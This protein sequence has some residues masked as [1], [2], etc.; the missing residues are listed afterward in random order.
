MDCSN[1]NKYI[2]IGII[3]NGFVGKATQLLKSKYT[4]V[5][6]YDIDPSKCIPQN[7]TIDIINTCDVIFIAVPT[8]MKPDGSCDTSIIESILHKLDNP[9]IIIRS[10][11]PVGFSHKHSCHFMPEFL[12]EAN[13]KNDFI[14]NKKWI[15]GMNQTDKNSY[16]IEQLKQTI[17]QLINNAYEDENCEIKYNDVIF[18]TNT[19]AELIK[20]IANTYLSTKVIYFNEI[21]ELCQSLHINYQSII[22]T[23]SYDERIGST[24]MKVPGYNNLK[25]Y[26]GT[27][28]PKDTNNL[29]SIMNEHNIYP[30]ILESNLFKNEFCY[31]KEH[32]WLSDYGRTLTK[33]NKKVILIT[34]GAGFIGSHL[35]RSQLN[36]GNIVICID[37]LST[38][39]LQNIKDI[40]SHPDFYFKKHDIIHKLYIPHID[41]IYHLACPAS[42]PKYQ[43]D[44]IKTLQTSF[45]GTMNVLELAVINKCKLLFTSTSEIYGDPLEH[46][47]RENYWGNVNPIGKRSCYD[48]GK[49][50]SETLLYEYRNK[51]NIDTKIVRVFNTYGPYMDINDGRVITNFIKS[52]KEEKPFTIYGDGTQTRSFCYISDL[53]DGLERM[54][55][56]K[57]QGPI[58]IGNPYNECTIFELSNKMSLLI[59]DT[60]MITKE[61]PDNI[62]HIYN[63]L[64]ENDPCRRCPDITLAMER[65]N[66]KPKI[67]IDEGIKKTIDFFVV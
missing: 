62:L 2:N 44:P 3:G 49:R 27:C 41:E 51:Y 8:P 13:W 63:T 17:T 43:L 36:K 23:L 5:Y 31:R 20:L 39:Y 59:K 53:I 24:H 64:P 4:N 40:S 14:N 52:I 7:T 61:N 35:C 21:Y 47:Q 1:Y 37:N 25:G 56:S 46:P 42:P 33:N 65:L 38:G 30:S 67:D 6:V 12:T 60:Q 57:E 22:N 66:W 45:V 48:E 15:F 54:M 32:D 18:I 11:I 16:N 34:G 9:N 19:E 58:N 26:G 10:T 29:Y 55:D 50:I 28:F